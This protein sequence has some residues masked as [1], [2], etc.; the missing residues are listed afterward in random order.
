[1]IDFIKAST[2]DIEL[3]MLSRLEMLRVVNGT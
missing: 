1:M 2:E 3:L